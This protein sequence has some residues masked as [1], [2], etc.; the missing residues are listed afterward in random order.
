MRRR[1]ENW[2]SIEDASDYIEDLADIIDN[3]QILGEYIFQGKDMY[4]KPIDSETHEKELIGNGGWQ[5]KCG[6][7]NASYVGTCRCGGTKQNDSV[8]YDVAK[9]E[10]DRIMNYQMQASQRQAPPSGWMCE[11]GKR[12]AAYQAY[13]SCGV[14]QTD[15]IPYAE[16]LEKSPIRM[17]PIEP[18]NRAPVQTP[19]AAKPAEVR[20]AAPVRTEVPKPAEPVIPIEEIQDEPLIPIVETQEEPL[21]PIEEMQEEPL[22]PIAEKQDE[23]V[24]PIAETQEDAVFSRTEEVRK[25][26]T[27]EK[28]EEK[29]REDIFGLNPKPTG[30][31]RFANPFRTTEEKEWKC[32]T[33]GAIRPSFMAICECGTSKRDNI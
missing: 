13:C 17:R 32:P 11:C 6:S 1:S 18:A 3:V 20:T 29:E 31:K 19:P 9:R 26:L 25:V 12:N 27:A 7:V 23:P 21:I 28:T 14:A 15:G 10:K 8:A 33:C 5:C 16:Y 2:I 4:T 24:I 22:I 30:N